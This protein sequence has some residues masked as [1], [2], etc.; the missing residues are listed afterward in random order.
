MWSR[1]A[2]RRRW[3]PLPGGLR[4]MASVPP[5]GPRWPDKNDITRHRDCPQIGHPPKPP[6]DP[7]MTPRNPYRHWAQSLVWDLAVNVHPGRVA[8]PPPHPFGLLTHPTRRCPAPQMGLARIRFR[9]TVA[10]RRD[11]AKGS[12]GPGL[13]ERGTV[14]VEGETPLAPRKG[15]VGPVIRLVPV[16]VVSDQQCGGYSPRWC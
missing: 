13:K 16:V 12:P 15:L 6:N 14:Q 1:R 8:H 10:V 11:R 2:I 9:I 7:P 3:E 4:P 5:S